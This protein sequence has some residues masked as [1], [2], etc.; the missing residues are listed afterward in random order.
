MDRELEIAANVQRSIL[1]G[2]LPE[3]DD[4]RF[5][6][7]LRPARQIGGDLYNVIDLDKDHLGI[8]IADVADKSVQAALYMA[9]I[10]TLFQVV[11]KQ[12]ISPVK[13]AMGVHNNLMEVS[14]G[15][16]IFVTAFYGVLCRSK[17]LLTYIV[18]GQDRP[19]L[20]RQNQPIQTLPGRGRFLGMMDPLE[21][22]EYTFQLNAGDRLLL[23]SDGAVDAENLHKEH[24]GIDRLKIVLDQNRNQPLEQFV[25]VISQEINAWA[26]EMPAFDDLTLVALEVLDKS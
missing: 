10:T 2:K 21:L 16:D 23:Y 3:Y 11:S 8:L 25:S 14:S 13:V 4:Y 19:L 5:A 6:A 17:K 7:Y 20:L 18:A 12:S 9:V 1:P 22:D 15:A 24:F 26:G